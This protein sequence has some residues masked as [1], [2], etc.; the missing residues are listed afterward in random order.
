MNSNNSALM[1]VVQPTILASL[2]NN[3]TNIIGYYAIYT[4]DIFINFNHEIISMIII[5]MNLNLNNLYIHIYIYIYI[6]LFGY[7]YIFIWI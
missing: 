6:Y 3:I 2:Y 4:N 7:I 1:Q 5:N